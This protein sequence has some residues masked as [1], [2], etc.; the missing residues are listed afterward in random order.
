M[1]FWTGFA[2]LAAMSALVIGPAIPAAAKPE[3]TRRTSKDCS[4]CHVPPGYNLNEAGK[5]YAEH[6]HSLKGYTPPARL[7]YGISRRAV[8]AAGAFTVP[9]LCRNT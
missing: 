7:S 8:G 6:Q 4:F 1:R 5:Y 9:P 3:Y 2:L